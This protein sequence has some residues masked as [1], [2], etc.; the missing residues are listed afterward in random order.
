[1][2]PK[3]RKLRFFALASLIFV[4]GC[5][6]G[7]MG[8]SYLY[9]RHVFSYMATETAANLSMRINTLSRLRL[10]EVDAAIES[11]ESTVDIAI[12]SIARTPHIPQTDYRH[13]A[14][15]GAKTY[16]EIYPSKSEVAP[17]VVEA[18]RNIPKIEIFKC[19][20]PLCRLVKQQKTNKENGITH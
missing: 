17:Q 6:L 9:Y 7:L 5:I 14:L 12:T 4:L 3:K 10:G 1:M 8:S 2:N 19:D 15:R 16:R 18:L 13:S 11:L 20:N